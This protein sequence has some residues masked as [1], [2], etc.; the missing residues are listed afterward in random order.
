MGTL[1]IFMGDY[2]LG[3]T[4]L[5]SPPSGP[6]ERPFQEPSAK[7]KF[8]AAPTTKADPKIHPCVGWELEI[9][10]LALAS[11]QHYTPCEHRKEHRRWLRD[12]YCASN[13]K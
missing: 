11:Q 2:R 9:E 12:H 3:E 6:A 7:S 1:T 5:F 13:R 8:L 4:T 10:G